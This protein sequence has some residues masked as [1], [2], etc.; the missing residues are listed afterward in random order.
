M[1]K[2]KVNMDSIS[3]KE[4]PSGQEYG[5]LTNRMKTPDRIIET[6]VFELSKLLCEGVSITPGVLVGK[7]DKDWIEQTIFCID[8]DNSRED[9]PYTTVE[10]AID[11]LSKNNLDYSFI[12]YT[13]SHNSELPD[14]RTGIIK[15]A[16]P[17]FRIVLLSEETIKDKEEALCINKGLLYLFDQAD[18]NT[19][20]GDRIFVGTNKGLATKVIE[21]TFNKSI[22][23]KLCELQL[24]EEKIQTE[25]NYQ[26]NFSENVY[27]GEELNEAIRNFSIASYV[28]THTKKKCPVCGHSD[29]FKLYPN[30][31]YAC[32]SASNQG[33][34]GVRGNNGGTII[35]LIKARD[36]KTTEEACHYFMY[37]ILGWDL[38]EKK[39]SYA[40]E[41]QKEQIVK[42]E[43]KYKEAQ[44][45]I[46]FTLNEKGYIVSSI[47][48]VCLALR[49]DLELKGKIRYNE[50][51][52]SPFVYGTLPWSNND[53]YREWTNFDDS[54]LKCYIE[55]KYKIG[56]MEKIN[57]ALNIVTGENKF[58]PIIDYLEQLKWDG[59]PRIAN[60]LSDYLG[61]EKNEYSE[62]ALRLFM[63]GAISRAYQPGCKFD[64][65]PVLV[66]EQGV[67]KSTFFKVL[68]GNDAWYNDNFN[69]VEGDK[70]AEKLRG[71]WIVELAE[72][73]AA[74]KAKEVESIKAF[75]TSTVDTYRQ[76]YSRR[77]EQRPR[78]CVFAGTTNN[79]HFMTDRTGNRRYLPLVVRKEYV[80]KS[81]FIKPKEVQEEFQQAWA[82]AL[83]IY[84]TEKPMLIFPEHLQKIVKD[85]QSQF[86]EEDV[87]VGIIQNYLES[88]PEPCDRVCVMQIWDKALLNEGRPLD[89]RTSNDIH[90]IM[91]SLKEQWVRLENSS[92]GRART[93]NYGV[94]ICY[95]K[96]KV[97]NTSKNEDFVKVEDFEEIDQMFT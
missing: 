58:N 96:V 42:Q 54:N 24:E 35:D 32:F 60:L 81:F 65:M 97:S 34:R 25:R 10:D 4:K 21:N 90:E 53:N 17:K 40:I 83:H 31:T 33:E 26:R 55:E 88:L 45:F 30:N 18:K 16:R 52:Y 41:K 62:T 48:N 22:P 39:K 80:K 64:Y 78:I 11:I 56:S 5:I 73:L 1:K 71:M 47:S 57:E 63:L 91:N 77:T 95:Q 36:S 2:F 93:Q 15:S 12:Y 3:Y 20:N 61:V 37:D 82:E 49:E 79:S 85:V 89:R 6:D 29:C 46:E 28:G 13:F 92:G 76:P 86:T 72:L 59:Q 8:I 84:K 19:I 51:S 43:K 94:Q 68:A 27:S 70:A 75:I 7:Q 67:G 50:L 14:K 9:I 66:G 38:H 44:K 74:K 87:R 69:T 23:F